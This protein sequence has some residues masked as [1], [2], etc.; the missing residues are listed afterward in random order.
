MYKAVFS[1]VCMYVR[2]V[3]LRLAWYLIVLKNHGSALL[4]ITSSSR[5][6]NSIS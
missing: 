4:E 1:Y 2:A 6:G 5:K 3:S